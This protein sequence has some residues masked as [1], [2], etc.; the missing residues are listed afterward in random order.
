MESLAPVRDAFVEEVDVLELL[1]LLLAKDGT[2]KEDCIGGVAV[3]FVV[4][5]FVGVLGDDVEE[6]TVFELS[7]SVDAIRIGAT[8]Y[9]PVNQCYAT[10]FF[11]SASLFWIFLVLVQ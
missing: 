8:L 11:F 10:P 2:S 9:L 5:V 1:L 6:D 7:V 3:V 4:A